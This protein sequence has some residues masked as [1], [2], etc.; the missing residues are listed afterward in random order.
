MEITAKST[1]KEILDAYEELMQELQNS[2]TEEPKV[3]KEIQKQEQ[4][5]K[6]SSELSYE[7]II[8]NLSGLKIELS[9]AIDKLGERFVT[10]FKKFE[11]LNQAIQIEK[12]TLED[13][14]QISANADS[15]SVMIMAQKAKKQEFE[16][17]MS[18]IKSEFEAEISEKKNKWTIEQEEFQKKV[19]EEE[20]SVKKART[21][22]DEEYQYTLKLKRKKEQDA[23]DEK[24]QKLEK[25]FAERE[26]KI[27]E[28]ENEI[29]ELRKLKE[30]FPQEIQKAV[31][32]AVNNVTKKL[33]IEF[34]F[35]TELSAKD[36]EGTMK[37]KEQT[38]SNLLDK[39]KTL[40]ASMKEL[41]QKTVT[42]ETSVKDIAIKA[43]ES[44]SKIQVFE[45]NKESHTKE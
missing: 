10:E 8:Q 25:E 42:A 23:Y 18:F 41:S 45:K 16:T 6:K 1:K 14:Y 22:E 2:K 39:I 7:G 3:T 32:D 38:I 40:E 11:E 44:S 43:I 5:V 34:Q 27:I 26:A 19:K 24:A 13:L 21:R 9:S 36:V 28:A 29:S 31:D 12:Q 15:L 33:Q 17:E 4:I 20:E 37:L 35:Q 30:T